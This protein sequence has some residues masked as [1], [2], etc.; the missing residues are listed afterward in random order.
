MKRR[1][2]LL[3]RIEEQHRNAVGDSNRNHDL[4]LVGDDAVAF[5]TL[6]MEKVGIGGVDNQQIN[7]MNLGNSNESLRPSAEGMGEEVPVSFHVV[8]GVKGRRAKIQRVVGLTGNTFVT[9]RK[10]VGRDSGNSE[11]FRLK[12]VDFA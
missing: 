7:T 12:V 11:E 1:D 2:N 4:R 9:G 3:Y 10:A 6:K 8:R 5:Q